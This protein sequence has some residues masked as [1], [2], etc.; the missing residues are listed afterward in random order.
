MS[1]AR[2]PEQ[3]TVPAGLHEGVLVAGKYRVGKPLGVGGMG[4][5]L[6]AVHE[7]LGTHVALKVIH[8]DSL[9]DAS[10]AARFV[11]EGRA[12][13]QLK[14]D[15]VVRVHDLGTLDDG[16]PFLAMERLEGVDLGCLLDEKKRLDV[17]SA[18][19]I[20]RQTCDALG[21]AHALGI[22]HRDLKPQNL[23]LVQRAGRPL[24][25]KVLDFGIA[26]ILSQEQFQLQIATHS[27]A[28]M[29][30]PVYMAPEQM[31]AAKAADGRSDL[32]S[33]G[34]IF[35]QLLAGRVPFE[36]ESLPEL[37]ARV[38]T[39]TAPPLDAS[40]GLP[41]GLAE[42]VLR[43][44]ENEP[45]QRFA[46]AEQ[47][48]EALTPFF[49]TKPVMLPEVSTL[50]TALEKERARAVAHEG[51]T[52]PAATAALLD[53]KSAKT[54]A[55]RGV[56]V[57][58]AAAISSPA[59]SGGS[60]S[61]AA[62]PAASTPV[63]S[64][65]SS[66]NSTGRRK[67]IAQVLAENEP[68]IPAGVPKESPGSGRALLVMLMAAGVVSGGAYLYKFRHQPSE[69]LGVAPHASASPAP[70]APRPRSSAHAGASSTPIHVED[71]PNLQDSGS[72]VKQ[73]ASAAP[74]GSPSR[75]HPTLDGGGA[76]VDAG[77]APSV[78]DASGKPDE[79][80]EPAEPPKASPDDPSPTE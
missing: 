39:S 23:F 30:S 31:R 42:V 19:E 69:P 25:V 7:A 34:V 22:V 50:A 57:V 35:Y 1:A 15:H 16:T 43:C 78:V 20:V 72:T 6:A 21:E 63:P 58:P 38:L 52:L 53:A 45:N 65:K 79:A 9:R 10:I 74:A 24:Q 5:V 67:T 71:T 48:V 17:D 12:A 70:S 11:Q 56:A 29:G 36:A 73:L 8:K 26:K 41:P 68:L 27:T 54:V 37:C 60:P 44:L 61:G 18:I 55:D 76:T 75:H 2:E 33:L 51:A 64:G 66:A 80:T 3:I 62:L 32:W 77:A 47:L 4:L 49:T 13:A 46:T 40:L 28:I 59:L 14:S